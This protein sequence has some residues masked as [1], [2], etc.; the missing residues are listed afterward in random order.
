MLNPTKGLEKGLILSTGL[1]LIQSIV[2]SMPLHVV[3]FQ[4]GDAVAESKAFGQSP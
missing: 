1:S 3:D 2:L 4:E